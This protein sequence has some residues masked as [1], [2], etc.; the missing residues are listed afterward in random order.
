MLNELR[1]V[2]SRLGAVKHEE[3]DNRMT[4]TMRYAV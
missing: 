1:K 2:K 4:S 3:L